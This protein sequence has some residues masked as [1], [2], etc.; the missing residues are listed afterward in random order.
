MLYYI[1]SSHLRFWAS[2][3]IYTDWYCHWLMLMEVYWWWLILI[4]PVWCWL[5][6]VD[7]N[8]CWLMQKLLS[9]GRSDMCNSWCYTCQSV[10]WTVIFLLVPMKFL[11]LAPR[12]LLSLLLYVWPYLLL[13]WDLLVLGRFPHDLHFC[14]NIKLNFFNWRIWGFHWILNFHPTLWSKPSPSHAIKIICA[15]LASS[16]AGPTRIQRHTS[17]STP[18]VW[19]IISI[20]VTRIPTFVI[21]PENLIKIRCFSNQ[22]LGTEDL[23]PSTNKNIARFPTSPDCWGE[24]PVG[25]NLSKVSK[26]SSTNWRPDP[27]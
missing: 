10:T 16:G 14:F 6:P 20:N 22:T 21:G 24:C 26:P 9:R 4:D 12:H 27:R 7:S 11:N 25:L 8:W 13:Y 18:S 19:L 15:H 5:M 3:P 2:M 17:P 1:S 23:R